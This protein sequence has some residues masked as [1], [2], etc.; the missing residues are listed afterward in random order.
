MRASPTEVVEIACEV[1]RQTDKAWLVFDGVREVWIATSQI[2][3][4]TDEQGR[5]GTKVTSIF[6]PL[7]LAREKGLI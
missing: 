2:S 7:W 5:F 1:K 6:V 4:Q 3:D